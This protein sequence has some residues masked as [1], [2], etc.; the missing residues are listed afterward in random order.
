M[1]L[2]VHIGDDSSL[3]VVGVGDVSIGDA[4]LKNVL[5]V[6]NISTNLFSIYKAT[7]K[8]LWVYFD[9]DVIE[10]ID[11]KSLSLVANGY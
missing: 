7:S 9:D 4:S 10:V 8:G 6:P 3:L 2:I 11:Q 5:H 1:S